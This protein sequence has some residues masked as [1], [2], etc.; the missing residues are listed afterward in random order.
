MPRN[1]VSDGEE[2]A[3]AAWKE[4]IKKKKK[5]QYA[6]GGGMGKKRGEKL[7]SYKKTAK[8]ATLKDRKGGVPIPW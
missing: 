3:L 1:K 7:Q 2:P 5:T 6:R 4:V 8:K